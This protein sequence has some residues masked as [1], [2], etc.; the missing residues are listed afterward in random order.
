M[1]GL[2]ALY[3]RDGRPVDRAAVRA[4]LEAIPYRGPDGMWVRL[5]GEV[6]LGYGKLG[7]TPEEQDEQQPLVSPRTGCAI[8]ADVRLDNRDDLLARLPD[9]VTTTVSDAELILRA[10]ETWGADAA[11]RLLG[12]FAFVVW[13]PRQQRLVCARDVRGQRGLFYR[14]DC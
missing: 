13:D 12:D 3:R 5:F 14:I 2:A 6:G 11:L 8:I 7:I 9:R 4:M 10:Y 1:S